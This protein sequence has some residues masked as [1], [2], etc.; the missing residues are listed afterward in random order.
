MFDQDKVKSALLTKAQTLKI[1]Y[2][3]LITV[4]FTQQQALIIVL[5]FDNNLGK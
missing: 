2:D 3:E 5:Q 1:Y 4:G